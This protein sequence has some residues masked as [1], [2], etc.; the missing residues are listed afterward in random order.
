[1]TKTNDNDD[2]DPDDGDDA[3]GIDGDGDDDR[4]QAGDVDCEKEPGQANNCNSSVTTPHDDTQIKRQDAENDP[5]D[6][7]DCD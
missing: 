6:D 1:M 7:Y 3:D 4:D 2:T 5:D